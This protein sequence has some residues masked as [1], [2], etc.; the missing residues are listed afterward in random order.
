MLTRTLLLLLVSAL[1]GAAEYTGRLE[2]EA[3]VIST[4]EMSIRGYGEGDATRGWG[5]S[6]ATFR[7]EYWRVKDD[8]WNYG[9]VLQPLALSYADTLKAD[10]SA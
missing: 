7:L 1:A 5:R 4:R 9:L 10:F 8:D 6:A 2:V 3:G